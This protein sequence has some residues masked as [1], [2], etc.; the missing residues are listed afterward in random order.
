MPLGPTLII[1]WIKKDSIKFFHWVNINGQ[2]DLARS[3][4]NCGACLKV[5]EALGSSMDGKQK[6]WTEITKRSDL[7]KSEK[8]IQI[9]SGRLSG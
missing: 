2:G 8:L 3:G 4:D 7:S 6:N 9:F 1:D 5:G